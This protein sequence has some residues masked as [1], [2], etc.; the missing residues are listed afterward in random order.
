MS[1]FWP[2]D[3]LA[4]DAGFVFAGDADVADVAMAR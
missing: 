1:G 4:G 2:D 3:F